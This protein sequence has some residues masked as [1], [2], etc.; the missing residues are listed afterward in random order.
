MVQN[1]IYD[2]ISRSVE[3]FHALDHDIPPQVIPGE[4][5]KHLLLQMTCYIDI[6][7]FSRRFYLKW[8]AVHSDYA[9]VSMLL[10]AS[11]LKI[12]WQT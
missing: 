5:F 11:Y 1:Y 9:F 6:Y 7:A 2:N 3:M 8:L 10:K 4:L 12:K